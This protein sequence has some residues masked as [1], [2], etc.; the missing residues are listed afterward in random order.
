MINVLGL[1]W[2]VKTGIFNDIYFFYV[3]YHFINQ[4][5]ILSTYITLLFN[6]SDLRT[7]VHTFN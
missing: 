7:E 5:A 2:V 1:L 6:H 4:I 3:K